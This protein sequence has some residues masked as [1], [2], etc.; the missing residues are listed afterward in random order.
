M[1]VELSDIRERLA[2]IETV[3]TIQTGVLEKIDGKLDGVDHRLAIVEAKDADAATLALR[4]CNSG[5]MAARA[6]LLFD[7]LAEVEPNNAKGEY[8]LTD[9]V[10]L[11]RGRGLRAASTAAAISSASTTTARSSSSAGATGR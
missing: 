9:A 8:Y 1:S 2:R 6:D 11:A 4:F 7:L 10:S 5:V 3:Q